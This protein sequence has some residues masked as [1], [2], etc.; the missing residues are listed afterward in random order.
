MGCLVNCYR[1]CISFFLILFLLILEFPLFELDQNEKEIDFSVCIV[2]WLIFF[3]SV[4]FYFLIFNY[5]VIHHQYFDSNIIYGKKQSQNV[6]YYNFILLMFDLINALLFHSF[7]VLNKS[8]KIEAKY[9]QVFILKPIYIKN[10]I[11]IVPI[12]SLTFI[13]IGIYNT[14]AFSKLKLFGKNIFVFNERV[15]FFGFNEN[16]YGNFLIGW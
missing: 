1:I 12:I 4:V 3:C 2:F 9:S 8:Q 7:W 15:D 16:Y 13:I 10:D 6:N 5:S 14:T 11:N